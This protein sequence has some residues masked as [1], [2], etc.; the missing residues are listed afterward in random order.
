VLVHIKAEEQ[1]RRGAGA[2]HD[3]REVLVD[4]AAVATG[5]VAICLW[6]DHLPLMTALVPVL[7]VVR[8]WVWQRAVARHRREI[9]SEL[10]FLLICVAVGG[11]NDWNTVVRHQVYEYTVP[12]FFPEATTIPWWMLLFWGLVLRL[13]AS[14][15]AWSRL[16]LA[17]ISSGEGRPRGGSDR[18]AR[19]L[20]SAPLRLGVILALL[21][22][23]R[24][25]IFRF[26]DDP[27]LSW[28]PFLA[29]GLVWWGLLGLSRAETRLIGL[30][31]VVGPLVE[32]LYIQLGG[33]HRYRLG[34]V[35]GVPLWIVLWWP[36][37]VL[38]WRELAG[39]LRAWLSADRVPGELRIGRPRNRTGSAGSTGSR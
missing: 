3:D 29:A 34:W 21:L 8:T 38:T 1:R 13:V 6:A 32:I 12:V 27:L 2:I 33:L 11:F 5:S 17:P 4:G 30:T 36:L 19:G 24:Q 26:F 23:T 20:Q 35:G 7:L 37:A 18:R 15:A 14:L 10:A 22:L 39:H 31:L 28:L 9:W 16:G 25:S